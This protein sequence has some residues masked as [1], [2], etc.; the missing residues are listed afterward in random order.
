MTEPVTGPGHPLRPQEPPELRADYR[1]TRSL[2]ILAPMKNR[3]LLW[4]GIGFVVLL[5]LRLLVAAYEKRFL[6]PVLWKVFA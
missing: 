6:G 4:A 3:W 2:V 1:V 5:V